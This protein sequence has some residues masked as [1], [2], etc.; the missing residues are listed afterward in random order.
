MNNN[1]FFSVITEKNEQQICFYSNKNKKTDKINRI[2]LKD[3][4]N[5]FVY[6]TGI[7]NSYSD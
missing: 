7:K 3:N 2:K 5:E 1:F 4:G 6:R